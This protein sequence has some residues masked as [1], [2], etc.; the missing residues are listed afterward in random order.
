ML[1]RKFG[2][3]GWEVAA[4]GLGTWNIGNQWGEMTDA[5][6]EAIVK[7]AIDEGMNLIDTAES[8][9]I[10]NGMSELRVG[11]ALKGGLRDKVYLV[12]KIGHWGM[13]TG[14]GVPKTTADMIRLCGHACAGRL[15]TDLI[16]VMLCHEANIEDPTVFIEGFR[17]LRDEGYIREYG[18]STDSLDVLERFCEAS[19]GECR[20]TEVEYS[21]LNRKAEG[22]YLDFCAE[23]G[24]GILVR[25]PLNRGILSGRFDRDTV[26]T[27]TVRGG[28]NKGE[29]QRDYYER[30]LDLLEKVR[31]AAPRETPLATT[32]LRFVI[33]HPS[34]PVVIPGATSPEQVVANA[35]AGDEELDREL[36]DRL[37]AVEG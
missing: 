8:Y 27:D 19:A 31:D 5:E 13:R 26:F 6:A 2:S 12:S 14:Q 36:Y 37:L 3:T 4:A 20:A 34:G 1:R 23:N 24:I 25:G 21:L 9:G 16:D 30:R 33:S 10:P 35:R 28:W 29:K 7:T 17:A 22:G 11:R 18:I 15:G 32:A